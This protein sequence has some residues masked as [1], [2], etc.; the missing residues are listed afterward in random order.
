[1]VYDAN[2]EKH[3]STTFT[4]GAD[5][6]LEQGH[7]CHRGC[8]SVVPQHPLSR[9]ELIA[10]LGT[11]TGELNAPSNFTFIRATVFSSRSRANTASL[12]QMFSIRRIKIVIC[13]STEIIQNET[14]ISKNKIYIFLIS[15]CLFQ[16]LR[17]KGNA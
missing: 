4:M 2:A 11:S 5:F 10:A 13:L 14:R 12:R 7:W 6:I 1:M 15:K 17:T 16:L 9:E 3:S 8:R